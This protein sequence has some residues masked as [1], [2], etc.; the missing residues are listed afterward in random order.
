MYWSQYFTVYGL[1]QGGSLM[2]VSLSVSLVS[3]LTALSVFTAFQ[4][5]LFSVYS[6]LTRLDGSLW[7]S[8]PFQG[9]PVLYLLRASVPSEPL[10]SN[11]WFFPMLILLPL[12]DAVDCLGV[13]HLLICRGPNSQIC[14]FPCF[15]CLKCR[16]LTPFSLSL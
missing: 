11:L 4:W 14:V 16:V 15:L 3:V 2:L 10:H 9:S 1:I 6:L 5:V 12:R 13:L 7:P 8:C